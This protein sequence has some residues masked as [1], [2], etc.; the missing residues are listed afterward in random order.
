MQALKPAGWFEKVGKRPLDL[1]IELYAEPRPA[2]ELVLP[3]DFRGIIKAE[4]HVEPDAPNPLGKRLFRYAVSPK[5]TVEIIGPAL[6]ER[7][8]LLDYQAV[9]ADGTRLSRDVKGLDMGFYAV[10]SDERVLTFFVG[11]RAEFDAVRAAELQGGGG[12]GRP[13][14]GG[15]G[16]GRHGGGKRNQQSTDPSASSGGS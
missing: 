6:V 1:A 15:G 16:G 13:G 9:T 14:S 7:V 2:V 5:G 12:S 11:T 4:L 8:V 3:A 10:K